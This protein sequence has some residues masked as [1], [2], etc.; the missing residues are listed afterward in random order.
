MLLQQAKLKSQ[1]AVPGA[2]EQ[3]LHQASR[4]SRRW[5]DVTFAYA[6]RRDRKP[7]MRGTRALDRRD[8]LRHALDRCPLSQGIAA[9]HARDQYRIGCA[10][11]I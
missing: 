3:G 11:E 9:H 5:R 7:G 4:S 1:L 10:A 2:P 6:G 8:V